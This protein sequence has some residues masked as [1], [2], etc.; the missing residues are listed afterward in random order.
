MD[1]RISRSTAGDDG[2]SIDPAPLDPA[3]FD[4]MT[5]PA[6]SPYP[7]FHP[8]SSESFNYTPPQ[9]S[10][11]FQNLLATEASQPQP[12]RR[13][14][15]FQHALMQAAVSQAQVAIKST[16]ANFYHPKTPRSA[17]E[18]HEDEFEETKYRRRRSIRR[19]TDK[20]RFTAVDA[21]EIMRRQ[22]LH[23]TLMVEQDLAKKRVRLQ[24]A[25]IQDA[26]SQAQE[27]IKKA[28]A[29]SYQFKRRHDTQEDQLNESEAVIDRQK[30]TII[31]STDRSKRRSTADNKRSQELEAREE[32][33][34]LAEMRLAEA[35]AENA[36]ITVLAQ[37][38]KS[39]YSKQLKDME[40][41]IMFLEGEIEDPG[42]DL[43]FA[44]SQA[45]AE[46]ADWRLLY[47]AMKSTEGRRSECFVRM[48]EAAR[49]LD[50]MISV[51]SDKLK[52]IDRI[53]VNRYPPDPPDPPPPDDCPGLVSRAP[54][55]RARKFTDRLS[56]ADES[57]TRNPPPP[58]HRKSVPVSHTFGIQNLNLDCNYPVPT[59]EDTTGNTSFAADDELQT[60]G[61]QGLTLDCD[62]D[63]PRSTA[64]DTTT[65]SPPAD[66]R[67]RRR[68]FSLPEYRRRGYRTRSPEPLKHGRR[69]RSPAQSKRGCR[70]PILG[71]EKSRLPGD[72]P[73]HAADNVLQTFGLQSLSLGG[74]DPQPAAKKNNNPPST[75]PPSTSEDVLQTFGLQSLSL[76]G[77]DPQPAEKK[78]GDNPSSTS[79][80]VSQTFGFQR[81]RLGGNDPQP[82]AKNNNPN[83][84]STSEDVSQTFGLQGLSLGGNDPQPAA[85]T[86]DAK[87][88][89]AA[90]R[91]KRGGL[92][93]LPE[94]RKRRYSSRSPELR[95]RQRIGYELFGERSRRLSDDYPPSTSEDLSGTFGPGRLI[96]DGS[97]PRPTA[98]ITTNNPPSAA[99]NATIETQSAG[100]SALNSS[101]LSETQPPVKQEDANIEPP[102]A[103]QSA[104]NSNIPSET[105]PP[106]K[107]E[108]IK[109]E[110]ATIEP[111]HAGQF[112]LNSNAASATD[113]T[114]KQEDAIIEPSHAGQFA[115]NSNVPSAT[116]RPIKQEDAIIEPF[117]ARRSA[118]NNNTQSAAQPTVREEDATIEPPSAGRS[119]LNNNTPS[120][121][122]PTVREE[123]ADR[124][125]KNIQPSP[126]PSSSSDF[127][128]GS[129]AYELEIASNNMRREDW[130]EKRG[131]PYDEDRD[132]NLHLKEV[133]M[134]DASESGEQFNAETTSAPVDLAAGSALATLPQEL[135][136]SIDEAL[137]DE[138]QRQQ[139][140]STIP[141][142]GN[143]PPTFHQPSETPIIDTPMPDA[144]D[145]FPS[146]P[147]LAWDRVLDSA[148]TAPCAP[149]RKRSRPVYGF[150]EADNRSA[151][152]WDG[153]LY[154]KRLKLSLP[155]SRP[156]YLNARKRWVKAVKPRGRAPIPATPA[157]VMPAVVSSSAIRG[158]VPAQVDPTMVE[159]TDPIVVSA[160]VI[161]QPT[162]ASVLT[163][164]ATAEE[165]ESVQPRGPPPR[166]QRPARYTD[167]VYRSSSVLGQGARDLFPRHQSSQQMG[168]ARDFLP[169]R[170]DQRQPGR[171]GQA[172]SVNSS[173][174]GRFGLQ[175]ARV[176][177]QRANGS[178]VEQPRAE[179]VSGRQ[180]AES[181]LPTPVSAPAVP[182]P[183]VVELDLP[184]VT[185]MGT[186][187]NS[188]S[189]LYLFLST[190]F[191]FM[192]ILGGFLVAGIDILMAVII[193][194]IIRLALSI[195]NVVQA[196]WQETHTADW[197][198]VSS[199]SSRFVRRHCP[200]RLPLI[201][202]LL[203]VIGYLVYSFQLQGNEGQYISHLD[204]LRYGRFRE[205]PWLEKID[206]WV[207][208][209][210][211][212]DR[213]LLG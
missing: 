189:Q 88:H 101:T 130:F 18:T 171:L 59:T 16:D 13:K 44:K 97:I 32:H 146:A 58:K 165:A 139:R 30:R 51:I 37:K 46:K 10:G 196:I 31:Q 9:G 40:A 128:V 121:A 167:T 98:E 28:D 1:R 43:R 108:A 155:V 182:D 185:F 57:T 191:G 112:A 74:S 47:E 169:S 170:W 69:S 8:P 14:V 193:P 45:K 50:E 172:Q 60:F 144:S 94:E 200:S 23:E 67:R 131:I 89:S 192:A 141:E 188:M 208:R 90:R 161:E 190:V 127:G 61:L 66:R 126:T 145:L 35:N 110:E 107:Q 111:S 154:V 116:D 42:A 78:N 211:A 133:N 70:S 68:L 140:P 210:L 4:P 79:E 156:R 173:V 49:H 39:S 197:G 65:N 209:W 99:G 93:S 148:G 158:P 84:P 83:P 6:S 178:Q 124:L 212:N 87:S 34:S 12:R 56:P 36:R 104:V 86:A 2:M 17:E 151:K 75:N 125:A 54:K 85:K 117:P 153:N 25:L 180:V 71:V 63:N 123:A 119:A 120:A 149:E 150:W 76:G 122:Q 102:C 19:S 62:N 48:D 134:P 159:P 163:E 77:N 184:K 206:F 21:A 109:Q 129:R 164:Q 95:K 15:S 103:G 64:K 53:M 202:A 143:A 26:V 138:E 157:W 114:I 80:D 199:L 52:G 3:P 92:S 204:H 187:S 142:S 24:Q 38:D 96:L 115:L 160:P 195:L 207:T 11:V 100:Q 20:K 137:R 135:L 198:P 72:N 183:I 118:S 152:S 41:R 166:I 33:I 177:S 147:R 203:V 205:W 201:L 181:G 5:A 22:E 73:R 132:L 106:I 136:A 55:S 7:S 91:R 174:S 194:A 113:R 162:V 81:L 29:N 176:S 105:Q 82:A 168:I 175:D 179:K 213:E 186:I 27:A